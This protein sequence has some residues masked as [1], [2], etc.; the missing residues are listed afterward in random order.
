MGW[1]VNATPRPLYPQQRDPVPTVQEAGYAPGTVW[2]S[3]QNGAP[4]SFDTRTIQSVANLYT[5]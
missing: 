4:T 5:D 2:A 1:V 3:A